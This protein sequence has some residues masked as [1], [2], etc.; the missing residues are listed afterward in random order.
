MEGMSN[1]YHCDT[2]ETLETRARKSKFQ[3][4]LAPT[5][6][7]ADT[8]LLSDFGSSGDFRF[9]CCCCCLLLPAECLRPV[10][11]AL[12]RASSYRTNGKLLLISQNTKDATSRRL[13]RE[14]AKTE[15][16][17]RMNNNNFEFYA[18]TTIFERILIFELDLSSVA[19]FV[20]HLVV[21]ANRCR[22]Q[23]HAIARRFR[24]FIY[25]RKYAVFLEY[26]DE[27]DVIQCTFW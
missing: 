21:G 24:S 18:Q 14:F 5:P 23:F 13:K 9:R 15:R 27:D 25:T 7:S 19:T 12:C 22:Y 16:S 8:T 6:S 20:C 10:W 4:V 11:L 1:R 17:T 3:R 26:E 2:G